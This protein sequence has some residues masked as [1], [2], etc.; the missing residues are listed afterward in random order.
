[1]REHIVAIGSFSLCSVGLLLINK[2]LVKGFPLVF[3]LLFLQF[4]GGVILLGIFHRSHINRLV[5]KDVLRWSMV[6]ITF[7][8]ILCTSLLALN[9][10]SVMTIVIF[11]NLRSLFSFLV[12]WK[13]MGTTVDYKIILSLLGIVIGSVIYAL[14]D[15]SFSV[16]G[17][18]V[19]TINMWAAIIERLII[20]YYMTV[21]KIPLD[22]VGM[23]FYSNLIASGFALVALLIMQ[24]YEHYSIVFDPPKPEYTYPLLLASIVLGVY[25]GLTGF[26]LQRLVSATSYLV[27]NNVNKFVIII[28][29]LVFLEQHAVLS[30]VGCAIA[31]LSGFYYGYLRMPPPVATYQP[32]VATS[33]ELKEAQEEEKDSLLAHAEEQDAE[34]NL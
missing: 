23:T 24:E 33:V 14:H 28:F 1:M 32:V 29:T 12:E 5:T 31:I 9:L 18:V 30:V 2:L 17:Y 13:T 16:A 20:K 15:V 26:R 22:N 19:L 3:T 10:V 34:E 25:I 4:V 11:N 7:Y 6:S 8:I 27:I 21:H